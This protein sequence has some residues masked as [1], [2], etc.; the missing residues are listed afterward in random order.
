MAMVDGS[1]SVMN[2]AD[3]LAPDDD[4]IDLYVLLKLLVSRLSRAE[5]RPAIAPLLVASRCASDWR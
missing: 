4:S 5:M 1:N 3:Y 2:S